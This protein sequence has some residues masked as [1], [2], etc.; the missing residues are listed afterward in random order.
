MAV[1]NF[2]RTSGSDAPGPDND[3]KTAEFGEQC[4]MHRLPTHQNCTVLAAPAYGRR[5]AVGSSRH[6]LPARRVPWRYSAN[7]RATAQQQ[8]SSVP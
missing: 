7:G 1:S 3:R 4:T 6:A 5:R 2:Y 8:C